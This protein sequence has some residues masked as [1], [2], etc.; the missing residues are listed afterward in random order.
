M[1]STQY[2]LNGV[3]SLFFYNGNSVGELNPDSPSS[4]VLATYNNQGLIGIYDPAVAPLI[5]HGSGVD[6]GLPAGT[7]LTFKWSMVSGPSQG[8]FGSSNAPSTTVIFG[9]PGVYVLRLTASDSELSGSDD[10]IVT[11]TGNQP[12]IVGAGADQSITFPAQAILHGASTDDGFPSGGADT[13]L[14]S[15]TSGQ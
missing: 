8:S 4:G 5:L 12:P 2:V 9:P 1:N 15:K 11:L 14:W 3:Q 10:L 6:D 13:V 7:N